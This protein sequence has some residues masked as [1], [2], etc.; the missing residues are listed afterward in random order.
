[1]KIA[2]TVFTEMRNALHLSSW[3]LK[4]YYNQRTSVGTDR[5]N[6]VPGNLSII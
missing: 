4:C 1:M 3:G 5:D 2:L 6:F